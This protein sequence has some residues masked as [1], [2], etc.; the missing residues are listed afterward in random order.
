[1][2]ASFDIP[3][4]VDEVLKDQYNLVKNQLKNAREYEVYSLEI[5]RVFFQSILDDF[6]SLLVVIRDS[7]MVQSLSSCSVFQFVRS[8]FLFVSDQ[9]SNL[10]IL[11]TRISYFY[12]HYLKSFC[13]S[14]FFFLI[15]V[16]PIFVPLKE[17]CHFISLKVSNV[18]DQVVSNGNLDSLGL[19]K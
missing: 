17:F 14:F 11:I 7:P 4:T 19:L 3:L 13:V 15:V 18:L 2:L 5:L 6:S 9:Y 8:A 1:M 10:L 12:R 16:N